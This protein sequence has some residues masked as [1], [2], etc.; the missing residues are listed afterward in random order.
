MTPPM[1]TGAEMRTLADLMQRL[2]W[3]PLD[4]VMYHPHPGTAT[5]ADVIEHERRT[6]RLCELVDGVL[7]EKAMGYRESRL[8]ALLIE[9]LN[10]FVRVPNLGIVTG[11]QGTV[12]L[13]PDLVRIPDVAFTS[14]NRMPGRRE[15]TEPIPRLVP[16]LAVEVL[17]RSNT[18][19]EMA[20]KRQDYFDAGVALVWEVD[21]VGR[22]VTVYTTPTASTTLNVG[23]TLDGGTVLPGFTLPLAELFAELDRAG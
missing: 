7:V 19:G 9:L 12:E 23:D 15:P 8:A 6:G 20:R 4:R 14:W 10:A 1:A 16:D 2:G 21:P 17:S 18:P 3:V 11:E 13:I 5:L 22:T